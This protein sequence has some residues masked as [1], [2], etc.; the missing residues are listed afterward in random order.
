MCLG[1]CHQYRHSCDLHCEMQRV[2]EKLGTEE[3]Q[4]SVVSVAED[5]R[6]MTSTSMDGLQ[7]VHLSCRSLPSCMEILASPVRAP[8]CSRIEQG[9]VSNGISQGSRRFRLR[10]IRSLHFS[11]GHRN[12]TV[13]TFTWSSC[14]LTSSNVSHCPYDKGNITALDVILRTAYKYFSSECLE[15]LIPRCVRS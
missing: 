10:I 9:N 8:T 12:S 2:R 3:Q 6:R 11:D 13:V 5:R 14:T 15:G 4:N 7:L 1:F